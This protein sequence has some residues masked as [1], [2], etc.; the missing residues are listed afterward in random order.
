MGVFNIWGRRLKWS[1]D[2]IN[3][4]KKETTIIHLNLIPDMHIVHSETISN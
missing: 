3:L 2:L 4:V 1:F